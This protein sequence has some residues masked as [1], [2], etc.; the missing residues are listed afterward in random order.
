[1]LFFSI[2]IP[3]PSTFR[4]EPKIRGMPVTISKVAEKLGFSRGRVTQATILCVK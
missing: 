2:S 4:E 1:M 3:H